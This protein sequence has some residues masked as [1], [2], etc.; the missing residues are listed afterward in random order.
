M[1]ANSR[2][3]TSNQTGNHDQLHELVDKHARS[4]FLKPITSYNRQSFE[5]AI[6]AWQ[7]AGSRALILDSGCGVGL[8]TRRLALRHPD[9]FVIGVDQSEDRLARDIHWSGPP[10]E[11]FLQVRA[12]VVDFWRLMTEAGL[13]PTSHYLL[14][15]NPWP[16]KSQ[17]GRRWHGHP[18]FPTLLALGGHIE[19]RSNWKIYIEEFAAAAAQL[20]AQTVCCEAYTPEDIALTPFEEKYRASGHALWRCR[21]SL[22][23]QTREKSS[24]SIS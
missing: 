24:A 2:P 9:A 13:H 19:C 11:N 7:Q 1:R 10:P 18:I 6:I 3:V 5:R 4:E 16:K 12:D 8:S 23:P 22:P 21:L 20:S 17:I 14:Y 15:P